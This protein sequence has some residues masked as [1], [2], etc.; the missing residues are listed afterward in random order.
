VNNIGTVGQALISD[1]KRGGLPLG[2]A[3]NDGIVE[4]WN[5]GYEPSSNQ[6]PAAK[7][8]DPQASSAEK[9]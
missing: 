2:N 3:W 1:T 9:F 6:Q 7:K 8:R 5:I 4:Q